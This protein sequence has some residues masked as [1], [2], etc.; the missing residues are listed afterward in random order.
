MAALRGLTG[1]SAAKFSCSSGDV[2]R[3]IACCQTVERPAWQSYEGDGRLPARP[4]MGCFVRRLGMNRQQ[5]P[6]HST[7]RVVSEERSTERREMS[8]RVGRVCR[9]PKLYKPIGKMMTLYTTTDQLFIAT[10]TVQERDSLS[11]RV[12]RDTRCIVATGPRSPRPWRWP[13]RGR[14]VSRIA[15]QPQAQLPR[16]TTLRRSSSVHDTT[17]AWGT[18]TNRCT[19]RRRSHPITHAGTH[20]I[21][22]ERTAHIHY[23]YTIHLLN[24]L[25]RMACA[26]K[27]LRHSSHALPHAQCLCAVLVA[28]SLP[29]ERCRA[30][31]RALPSCTLTQRGRFSSYAWL[32]NDW[33]RCG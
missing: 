5:Q 22:W 33:W 4:T 17:R 12:E 9:I 25:L 26:S 31:A 19:R 2:I 32:T 20:T 15:S 28:R 24:R 14:S 23:V 16:I 7:F 1:G 27:P 13:V 8:G 6:S 29:S 30:A 10:L 18:V 3:I 21:I 11:R